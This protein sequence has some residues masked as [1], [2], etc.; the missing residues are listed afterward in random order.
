MKEAG[1]TVALVATVRE[2]EALHGLEGLEPV[3]GPPAEAHV[4]ASPGVWR[5]WGGA[6]GASP[7]PFVRGAGVFAPRPADDPEVEY[8][9]VVVPGRGRPGAPEIRWFCRRRG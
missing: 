2:L 8:L 5:G 3:E 6:M 9:G 7:P 4:W 1:R